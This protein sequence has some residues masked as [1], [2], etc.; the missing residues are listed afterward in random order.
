MIAGVN[1]ALRNKGV[2]STLPKGVLLFCLV[3]FASLVTDSVVV[4]FLAA[5]VALAVMVN[6][7][8]ADNFCF[9]LF[10]I[11]NI[12]LLDGSGVLFLVNVLILL[13]LFIS[14]FRNTRANKFALVFTL[15]LLAYEFFHELV[16]NQYSDLV[17]NAASILT[18]LYAWTFST[19]REVGVDPYKAAEYL[20][21]GVIASSIMCLLSNPS[22]AQHLIDAIVSGERFEAFAGDPN[23]FS[24]YICVALSIVLISKLP[25]S[26]IVTL[27]LALIG[28]GLLT[29]SKMELAVSFMI[30]IVWVVSVIAKYDWKQRRTALALCVCLLLLAFAFSG[31]LLKL[32][33]HLIVRAGLDS[34]QLNMA[35]LSTNRSTILGIY[36]AL[37]L[38]NPVLFFFGFGLDYYPALLQV[39]AA[40]DHYAHNTYFDVLASWGA[41][42]LVAVCAVLVQWFSE[43]SATWKSPSRAAIRKL[44]VIALAVCIFS[45]SCLNSSMF[46]L[47]VAVAGMVIWKEPVEHEVLDNHPSL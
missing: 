12:R 3:S 26:R 22:Y 16:F 31:A 30:V 24:C 43:L 25:N 15:G 11:P 8:D 7:D 2:T 28:I 6:C 34:G 37:F 17:A 21:L 32:L 5:F 39:G 45:L 27:A 35:Q 19:D 1:R 42:G 18:L 23:Y 36:I 4:T 47:L 29:N 38:H 41:I 46:W 14:I 13:P 44:P 10:L 20:A 33:N 40:V 9:S